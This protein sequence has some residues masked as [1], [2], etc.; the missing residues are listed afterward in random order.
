MTP[1]VTKLNLNTMQTMRAWLWIMFCT[2]TVWGRWETWLSRCLQHCPP[3][4]VPGLH[5]LLGPSLWSPTPGLFWICLSAFLAE[6]TGLWHYG[7]T[8][9][10][11]HKQQDS[12]LSQP[13][14]SS[15]RQHTVSAWTQRWWRPSLTDQYGIIEKLPNN[16]EWPRPYQ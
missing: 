6:M 4:G 15:A 8:A 1:H 11:N 16:T 12:S 13:I 9:R 7:P 3:P 2:C 10:R 14:H 5:L